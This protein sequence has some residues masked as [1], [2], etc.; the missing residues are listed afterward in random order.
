MVRALAP[1]GGSAVTAFQRLR[2]L[3]SLAAGAMTCSTGRTAT[4]VACRCLRAVCERRLT[5]SKP[6]ASGLPPDIGVK[7]M[8][9]HWSAT[10]RK[11]W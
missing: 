6:V 8:S 5:A 11:R 7:R 1:G 10:E 9:G 3:S 2:G 4:L